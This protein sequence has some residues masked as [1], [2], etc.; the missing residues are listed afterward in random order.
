MTRMTTPTYPKLPIDGF[1]NILAYYDSPLDGQTVVRLFTSLVHGNIA[2][3]V[4]RA[5]D[6]NAGHMP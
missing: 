5:D 3:I 1:Q 6:E 2:A 4:A